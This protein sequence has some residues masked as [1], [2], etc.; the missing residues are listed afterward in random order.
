MI[1][2]DVY[3]A[4]SVEASVNRR[5]SYGGTAPENLKKRLLTLKKRR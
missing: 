5:K 1:G 4:L 3:E 2:Q